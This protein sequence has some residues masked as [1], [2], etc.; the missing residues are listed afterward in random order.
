MPGFPRSGTTG[1]KDRDA[2]RAAPLRR[3]SRPLHGGVGPGHAAAGEHRDRDVLRRRVAG[4]ADVETLRANV[5]D[6]HHADPQREIEVFLHPGRGFGERL[7]RHRG[8]VSRHREARAVAAEHEGKIAP[9]HARWSPPRSPRRRPCSPPCSG[10]RR[11][12]WSIAPRRPRRPPS[13]RAAGEQRRVHHR[14]E[15]AKQRQALVEVV[16]RGA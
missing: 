14:G 1:R 9:G 6:R 11:W 3:R 7:A 13:R 8:G 2:R 12:P 5:R 10:S 15:V 4:D 16:G